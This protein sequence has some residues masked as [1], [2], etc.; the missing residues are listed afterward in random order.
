MRKWAGALRAPFELVAR[1]PIVAAVLV[2]GLVSLVAGCAFD[3]SHVERVQTTFQSAAANGPGWTLRQ[4]QSIDV[5]SGFPTVLRQDT[6]WQLVGHIPQGDVYK[7]SDQIVTVEASNI[8]EAMAVLQG[9]KLTGFYLPVE[10][11]F[12]A[13]SPPI[14]LPLERG[15]Q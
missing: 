14:A 6:H 2:A 13:A 1:P 8:F 10:A 5:G 9:D 15:T 3:V 7:T 12:V 11:S 4:K